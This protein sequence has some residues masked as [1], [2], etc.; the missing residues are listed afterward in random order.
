[1]QLHNS[2][3]RY[4]AVH[5][6]LHWLTA[7]LVASAWLLGTFMDGLPR[8]DARH[9]GIV[10]HVTIGLTVLLLLALRVLWRA[11]NTAPPAEPS[12]LGELSEWAARIVHV[13]LYI[14]LAAVPIAGIV[15]WLAR[16]QALPLFG[17]GAIPSPWAPDLTF[18]RTA[19]GI[20]ALLANAIMIIAGIHA[21]AALGHHYLFHDRTLRR[22]LP[23]R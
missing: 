12:P 8:G 10:L 18:A 23:G 9:A 21:A 11:V 20:H 22:I 2:S 17:L 19:I 14:L 13:A 6:G 4:G 7:L 5:V 3:E 1:M 15:Y 16:G